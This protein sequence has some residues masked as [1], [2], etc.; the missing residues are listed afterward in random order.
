MYLKHHSNLSTCD[1]LGAFILYLTN[2]YNVAL[3]S[4]G[5]GSLVIEVLCPTLE[6]LESLWDDY[7]A[8]HINE[9]AENYLVTDE[10]KRKLNLETVI[11]KTTIEEENYLICKEAFMKKPREFN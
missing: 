6:S 1:G 10:I 7:R 3:A 2:T 9:V 11:L 8:G 4:V 5:L